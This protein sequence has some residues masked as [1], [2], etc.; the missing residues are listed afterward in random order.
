ML[1][2]NFSIQDLALHIVRM[3]SKSC[4]GGIFDA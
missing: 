2:E 3:Q 1:A 4:V